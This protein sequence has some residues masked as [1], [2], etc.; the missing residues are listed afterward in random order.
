M[1]KFTFFKDFLSPYFRFLSE[2]E[3][4]IHMSKKNDM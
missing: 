4:T 3:L 2:L 1:H